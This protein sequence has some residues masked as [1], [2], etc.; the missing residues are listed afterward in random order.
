MVA[1]TAGIGY[2]CTEAP[3][4]ICWHRYA[5]DDEGTILDAKIVQ[6]RD[7]VKRVVNDRIRELVAAPNARFVGK[8][9]GD[10]TI[11]MSHGAVSR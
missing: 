1:T 7:V 2:A 10:I 5:I 6:L 9:P 11:A 8:L 3:R 4:G